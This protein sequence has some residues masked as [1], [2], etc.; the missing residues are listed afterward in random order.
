[1]QRGAGRARPDRSPRWDHATPSEHDWRCSG[2]CPI[3]SAAADPAAGNSAALPEQSVPPRQN[4]RRRGL[5]RRRSGAAATPFRRPVEV[6]AEESPQ[7]LA[8]LGI[9]LRRW[10]ALGLDRVCNGLV[11]GVTQLSDLLDDVAEPLHFV[12]PPIRKPIVAIDAN[13]RN[14]PVAVGDIGSVDSDEVGWS[15]RQ[16]DRALGEVGPQPGPDPGPPPGRVGGSPLLRA[17][18]RWR[19]SHLGSTV[20]SRRARRPP[21]GCSTRH[22][23]HRNASP[24]D[25]AAR[26]AEDPQVIHRRVTAAFPIETGRRTLRCSRGRSPGP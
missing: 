11:F 26:I 8:L 5:P 2:C 17:A 20:S 23:V 14:D 16:Q 25:L 9:E 1:M 6:A 21:R 24:T 13:Q 15:L 19:D 22:G 10:Y 7:H 18:A 12:A 4:A 3:R